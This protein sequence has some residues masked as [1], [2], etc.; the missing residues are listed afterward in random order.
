MVKFGAKLAF[1]QVNGVFWEKKRV[2][3]LGVQKGS[4]SAFSHCV[5]KRSP[6]YCIYPGLMVKFGKLA[7][8]QVNGAFWGDERGYWVFFWSK[9]GLLSAFSHWVFNESRP[10]YCKSLHFL[11]RQENGGFGG[12]ERGFWVFSPRKVILR[13]SQNLVQKTV[14]YSSVA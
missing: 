8:L 9:K 7:F 2:I 12:V 14:L 1:L 6:K 11:W 10:K 4:L 5:F 3:F 13:E